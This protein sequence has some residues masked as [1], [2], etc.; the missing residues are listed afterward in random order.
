MRKERNVAERPP[1]RSALRV[2]SV[3]CTPV[4]V[5]LRY[6]LGT[7]A[8]TVKAAPLL[9]VDLLTDEGVVGRSYVFAYRR[10]GAQAI[11]ALLEEAVELVRGDAVAPLAIAAK[12]QRRFALI[13][14]TGVARMALSALDMALWDALAVAA[15]VPLACLLGG[16]PRPVRAYNSCGLGLMAPQAA[17]DEAEALLEGGL[18]AVKLRLGYATLAEDLAATRAVRRRLPDTVQLMVDYNQ[19]LSRVEAL[20]RGRALQSEGVAWLEEPIRHDD[21]A[22]NA[23]IARDLQLPLQLGENFDG[24]KD[25]L[26]A[27]QAE[28]C[29]LVMPDVARIGGVSGWMQAAGIAEAHGIPMSSH[30][31]PEVSAHLLAATPTG[32]WLEYVDWTDAI[33][34]EPVKI[35][36]GCWP[37]G[38]AAGT[39]LAWDADKVARL[40][41]E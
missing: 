16:T 32:H 7:S 29:D 41:I 2:H 14:V 35:V 10:S 28:A 18:Q 27:L 20:A 33:A 9:L 13:G 22:G 25:L 40:R 26:R 11:A 3:T 5:P 21:L 37:I 6:V 17:A 12:L 36:D 30:L 4:Q 1:S 38:E 39:G 23:H 19:A 31:M 24:P 34:A 8:A 15:G